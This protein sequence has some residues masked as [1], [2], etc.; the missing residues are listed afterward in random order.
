[1]RRT[2]DLAVLIE[3]WFADRLLKHRGVSS[4]TIASHRAT[5][6]LLFGFAQARLGRAPSQLILRDLDA[7]FIGT[8]REE[9]ET[10]RSASVRTR[11]LPPQPSDPSSVM[12]R[13]RSRRIAPIFSVCSRSPASDVTSGGFSFEPGPR[14]KRSWTAR[15]EAR[16]WDPAITLCYCW[17]HKPDCGSRRSPI[18]TETP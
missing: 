1:M 8:F 7:P 14:L 3:R 6:R 15:I 5:F 18:W 16:G 10:K 17:P 2:N 4:N 9:L 13:S 11:N 12:Q